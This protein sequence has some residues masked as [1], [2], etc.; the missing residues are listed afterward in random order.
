MLSVADYRRRTRKLRKDPL[1]AR[2]VWFAV[3]ESIIFHLRI[4]FASCRLA[5]SSVWS[6]HRKTVSQGNDDSDPRSR[7]FLRVAAFVCSAEMPEPSALI[8]RLSHPSTRRSR[9]AMISQSHLDAAIARLQFVFASL[10]RLAL[11]SHLGPAVCGRGLADLS[12]VKRLQASPIASVLVARPFRP[13]SF[14][15]GPLGVVSETEQSAKTDSPRL[16]PP[17]CAV[18]SVSDLEFVKHPISRRACRCK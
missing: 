16:V 6:R 11:L 15:N 13:C 7:C 12:S 5:V 10:Y 4:V 14:A 2:T 9:S 3:G 17:R 1:T 8:N 18:A